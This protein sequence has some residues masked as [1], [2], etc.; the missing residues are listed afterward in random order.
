MTLREHVFAILNLLQKGVPT[1]NVAYTP[2]LVAHF[3]GIARSE[4]LGK[5]SYT[6]D[7]Y[8]QSVC[9][10]F[11]YEPLTVCP[12][13]K[14]MPCVMV[15]R[16]TKPVPNFVGDFKLVTLD[17]VVLSKISPIETM[18]YEPKELSNTYYIENGHIVLPC[19]DYE[20]LIIQGI[21]MD[22]MDAD[23][24]NCACD[25]CS[26]ALDSPFNIPGENVSEVYDIVLKYLANSVSLPKRDTATN[27]QDDAV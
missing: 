3:L 14:S 7:E 27:L 1:Q 10:Q 5:L 22:P 17:G 8:V 2:Q 24:Y 15:R 23:E 6:K 21:L 25:D 4:V 19:D 12:P 26:S 20:T 18:F 9:V 16:S 13:I 11:V